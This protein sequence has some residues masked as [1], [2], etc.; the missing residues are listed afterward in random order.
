MEKFMS[1]KTLSKQIT[2]IGAGPV[3]IEAALYAKNLGYD[4]L[5]LERKKV[6]HNI[7]QW[8]HVTF[9]SPF[10]MNYSAPGKKI[11]TEQGLSL[12]S[13]ELYLSGEEYLNRYLLPLAGSPILKPHIVTECEVIAVSRQGILKGD[14][15]GDGQR[16]NFPFRILTRDPRGKENV[17]YS[18]YIIDASGTYGNHNWLGDGG[19]PARG[20]MLNAKRIQYG[21]E[22]ISGTAKL[23]YAGKTILLVG[24]GHSAGTSAV[25]LKKL[26][27]R[28]SQTRLI[29][30]TRSNRE[31]P[32]FVIPE[33]PLKERARITRE[34]N[35][36]VNHPNC[37]WIQNA[38]VEEVEFD[39][40]A[41]QFHV[42]IETPEGT[43]HITTDN[44]VANVGFAPDNNI[45]RE[46]QVHECY[47]SRAPMKLAAALLSAGS[48][49]DC[50]AQGTQG[51][52][53]LKNPEPDF[54]IL[55]MKSY[56]KNSNFLL[57]TGFEQIRDA[58]KLISGNNELDLY[59]M[60]GSASVSASAE[61][62]SSR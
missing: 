4:V 11:I 22:D 33:D 39:E 43:E 58:F 8:K 6:A 49:A 34:A 44:I 3:G 21:L 35:R 13:D 23:K 47:A 14:H 19:I 16:K 55:G 30:L 57:K 17:Y 5:I 42:E 31:K 59:A 7:R 62:V 51:P 20:E 60:P 53:V 2:I 25:A 52:E 45:Y 54:Y 41:Q 29:W 37:R 24:D 9:F 12:P 1:G 18:D 32:L 48:S 38:A 56:G 40:A 50:L 61:A 46:L 26:I 36:M 27:D 28:D 15:I 10:G